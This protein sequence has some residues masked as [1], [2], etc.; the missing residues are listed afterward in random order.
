MIK[1]FHLHKAMNL[2]KN[3]TKKETKS[4]ITI[5]SLQMMVFT[6]SFKS[7][8]VVFSYP[9]VYKLILYMVPDLSYLVSNVSTPKINF[10]LI[11]L[12]YQIRLY[13]C[14]PSTLKYYYLF[15]S[16]I[17][18]HFSYLANVDAPPCTIL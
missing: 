7:M 4:S 3:K 8:W 17:P 12:K 11:S 16:A 1:E 18:L 6:Q 15:I 9:I 14:T 10:V 2:C 13:C 5:I